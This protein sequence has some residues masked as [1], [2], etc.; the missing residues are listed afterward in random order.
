MLKLI[1]RLAADDK[2]SGR[3]VSRW[4]VNLLV[5]AISLAVAVAMWRWAFGSPFPPIPGEGLLIAAFPYLQSMFDNFVRSNET[6]SRIHSNAPNVNPHGG[7]DA[8]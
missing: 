6:R 3:K 2:L 8:P 1:E 4:A 7:P 5:A